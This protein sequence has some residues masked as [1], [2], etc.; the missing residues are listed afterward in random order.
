[1]SSEPLGK[2]VLIWLAFAILWFANIEHRDLFKTDEGR[3]AEI[4][5]EMLA[6]GDWVTPRLNGFVYFEKPPL[7]YW[8]TALSYRAFGQHNWTARL[9]TAICGFLSVV[10]VWYAGT[11]LF[12]R[13][14]GAYSAMV[15]A[16]SWYFIALGNFNS[17]DMGLAFFMNLSLCGFLLAQRDGLESRHRRFWMSLSWIAVAL[18]VLSKGLIGLVL[19]GAVL[20]VYS[21]LRRE[22]GLWRRLYLVSG[23]FL[24]L[25]VAAPWFVLVSLR[26]PDF[27]RFFFL[28]EHFHRY[29]TEMHDRYEPWWYFVP[30]LLFGVLPWIAPAVR[31]LL[32]GARR[33]WVTRGQFDP[34]SFLWLWVAFIFLFFSASSSKLVSYLLPVFPAF[35]LLIGIRLAGGGVGE[36]RLGAQLSLLAGLC[37][38][39]AVAFLGVHRAKGVTPEMLALFV[40]WLTA[41][42]GVLIL[43]GLVAWLSI[44]RGFKWHS[45]LVQSACWLLGT[46]FLL[47]GAQH[48]SPAYSARSLVDQMAGLSTQDS[49]FYSVGIYQHSLPFYLDR[50][51]TLVR[52]R[53]EMEYGISRDPHAWIPNVDAFLRIWA[54]QP[55]AFAV[56]YRRLLG[57]LEHHAGFDYRV[58]ASDP[59]RVIVAKP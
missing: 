27:P 37:G 26:N 39:G 16:G 50:T 25:L 24:F 21:L 7:Q 23:I 3:Y 31:E 40:P 2:G 55:K 53:G 45:V 33:L 13:E 52:F 41:S 20:V 36:A 10:L 43:G 54:S 4:P 5:R 35:S 29:L 28:Q 6:T 1:M 11:R 32:S 9:W 19:P 38:V 42:F 44:R 57:R 18:A 30:L 47:F 15:L 46:Q 51:L 34:V 48:L 14:A 12:G 22:W 56:M 59:R 49:A 58:V 8:M 17:L